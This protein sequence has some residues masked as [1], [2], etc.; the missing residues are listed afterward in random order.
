MEAPQRCAVV[1]VSHERPERLRALLR[2][3]TSHARALLAEVVVVDD[4]KLPSLRRDEFPE[5]D[6]RVIHPESR[7]FVSEARNR[8]LA[9]VRSE[10]VFI[11]DDD[12]VA[13]SST[14]VH[15][16]SLL[17]SRPEIAALM[18]SVLYLTRPNLVWVYATPFRPDR[19]HFE[20]IGRNRPR[21][22]ALEGRLLPTD[23][24]PNAAL[25]R[26]DV[27]RSLGGYDARRFPVSS[28]AD[29]C[30]RLKAAGHGVWA[31]SGAITYHDVE[32]PESLHYGAAH[33]TDPQRIYYD[34]RDWFEFQRSIRVGESAF[35]VRAL[36]HS[37][38]GL[39][40]SFV[41]FV[42]RP[43]ARVLPLTYQMARGVRDGLRSPA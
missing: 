8:G 27:L 41:G 28:T 38:R 10:F 20:L 1:I 40:A 17:A 6:L 31:D 14:L 15:P 2:S 36:W 29:L 35:A 7:V 21:N 42:L 32:P 23:A 9:E 39:A 24:L 18:P 34:K 22:P 30:Q 12:N 19:W 37:S 13:D 16:L 25:F 26:R 43:E 33:A 11:V 3:L 5:L 4:S